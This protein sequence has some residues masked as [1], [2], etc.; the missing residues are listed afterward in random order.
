MEV[1]LEPQ[2]HLHWQQNLKKFYL[3]K[4]FTLTATLILFITTICIFDRDKAFYQYC[5]EANTKIKPGSH[6][7]SS[8]ILLIVY[9]LI[10]II[11]LVYEILTVKNIDGGG[12]IKSAF[13]INQCY[14]LFVYIYVQ[15]VYFRIDASDCLD[16]L[17]P[18]G[19][20][21]GGWMAVQIVYFYSLFFAICVMGVCFACK[22]YKANKETYS[23]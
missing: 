15:T 7:K 23:S 20:M 17:A 22:Q 11:G 5:D 10:E 8:M 6:I 16:K 2:E 12:V 14:G 18:F 1:I 3:I 19:I 13:K 4:G 21:T 9:H